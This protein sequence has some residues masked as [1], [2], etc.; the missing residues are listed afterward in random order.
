MT[1]FRLFSSLRS[2]EFL[3]LAL[4]MRLRVAK[5]FSKAVSFLIFVLLVC[6]LDDMVWLTLEL[7][8]I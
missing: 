1:S 4:L 2:F 3:W 7:P 6:I 8:S 5:V